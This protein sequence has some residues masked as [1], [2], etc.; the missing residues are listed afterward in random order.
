MTPVGIFNGY[1]VI[2][3]EACTSTVQARRHRK[4]RINKK[5]IKRYGYKTVPWK[6]VPATPDRKL[7]MHPIVY[8]ALQAELRSKMEE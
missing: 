2:I 5:W 3:S 4:K 8:E 7:I 6:K 1:T